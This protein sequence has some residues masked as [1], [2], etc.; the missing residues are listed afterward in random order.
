MGRELQLAYR[1]TDGSYKLAVLHTNLM[2]SDN[3]LQVNRPA[4]FEAHK[5]LQIKFT[6]LRFVQRQIKIKS[7]F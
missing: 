2:S 7:K 5:K 4:I 6:C 3:S 1:S